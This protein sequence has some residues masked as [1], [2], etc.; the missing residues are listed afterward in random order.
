MASSATPPAQ[1]AELIC[2]AAR[3]FFRKASLFSYW[4][5]PGGGPVRLLCNG[6]EQLVAMRVLKREEHPY[7]TAR[8]PIKLGVALGRGPA[9]QVERDVRTSVSAT[10]A[11]RKRH[12]TANLCRVEHTSPVIPPA[13]NSKGAKIESHMGAFGTGSPP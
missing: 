4:F 6:I 13:S 8:Y 11:S 10:N 12:I 7:V 2:C 5:D 1:L 9:S 3:G